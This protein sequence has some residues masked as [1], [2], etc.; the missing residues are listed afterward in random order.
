[1]AHA[2]GAKEFA[3]AVEPRV[4]APVSCWFQLAP[5]QFS[6]FQSQRLFRNRMLPAGRIRRSSR[7]SGRKTTGMK[8]GLVG[9]ARSLCRAHLEH[10]PAHWPSSARACMC[11]GGSRFVPSRRCECHRRTTTC[12][13][14]RTLATCRYRCVGGSEHE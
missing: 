2:G 12:A 6:R 1:M 10:P 5:F 7:L 14:S 13:W 4:S 11:L 3:V 8:S 9:G